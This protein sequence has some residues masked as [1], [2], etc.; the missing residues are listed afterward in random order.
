M[1]LVSGEHCCLR[2]GHRYFGLKILA[3]TIPNY[4]RKI[5]LKRLILEI[6]T[7][8]KEGHLEEYIQICICDD[9]SPEDPTEIVELFIKEN[10][11][12]DIKYNRK[13]KN[14]GMDFNF[15]DSV[16]MADSKYCWIIGND[17]IPEQEAVKNIVKFLLNKQDLDFLV[18]PFDIYD[19]CIVYRDTI[20]PLSSLEEKK[21]DT[22]IR[23]ELNNLLLSIQHNSAIFGFL[24][25]VVFRKCIW[26]E[27]CDTFMDKMNS[28]F[29]QMYINIYK[30]NKGAIYYYSPIKI[31]K[32]IADDIT[33]NSSERIAKILVGLDEVV[34]F[35]FSGWEK[36]HLKKVLTDAYINGMTWELLA[37]H[38]LKE[39]CEKIDSRKNNLYRQYYIKEDIRNEFFYKKP[40][41]IYGAGDYGYNSFIKLKKAKADIR[42]IAD[43]NPGKVGRYFENYVIMNIEEMIFQYH[44]SKC[45]IVV[46][47]HYGLV[48]M[49]D[50]L[51]NNNINNIAIIS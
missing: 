23:Y 38:P 27:Y 21:F 42:G 14:Q 19:S 25:N 47:C 9:A 5:E 44:N 7:Q 31:I 8:I 49:F 39:K 41:I 1:K 50:V 12:I 22:N 30:L 4:N 10:P 40:V 33:N 36:Q 17:D 6:I 26:E 29:I 35:F 18:T 2:K 32:N 45:V 24:S 11:C 48:D 16:L 46:A 51:I 43:S 34:E 15:R 20:N 13:T 37:N 28:I 3:I